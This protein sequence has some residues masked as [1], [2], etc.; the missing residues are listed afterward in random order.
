[1]I[2]ATSAH[3]PPSPTVGRRMAGDE[4]EA[5]QQRSRASREA[6]LDALD[7]LLHEQPYVDI[8]ISDIVR[9]AGLT[10]GALY[11]RFDGK[12]G[13][14][15]A[16]YERFAARSVDTMQAWGARPQWA[17]AS[18]EHII[19]SWTRGAVNFCRT[20]RPLLSLMMIDP[21]VRQRYDELME[22]PPRILTGLLQAATP[23]P[24]SESFDRDVEWA[25]RAALAVLER[26]DLDDD[27]LVE[28]IETMLFRLIG[29]D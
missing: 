23:N 29:V 18:P 5:K 6:L 2:E 14:E 9:R 26:F 4:I 11:A 8:G 19:N 28:R 10:T 27:D 20:H 22:H 21:V 12:R 16:L 13:L 25:S 1:M 15:L 24:V 17:T 7:A 3:P